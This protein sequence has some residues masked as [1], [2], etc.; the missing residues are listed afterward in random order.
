MMR[1]TGSK[2]NKNFFIQSA[3]L[4]LLRYCNIYMYTLN[5]VSKCNIYM[6]LQRL[7]W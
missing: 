7:S 6:Y 3:P 5:V 2:Y 4:Y 1:A